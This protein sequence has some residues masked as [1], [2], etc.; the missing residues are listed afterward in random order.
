MTTIRVHNIPLHIRKEEIK[1]CFNSGSET[2]ASLSLECSHDDPQ[3]Q[4]AT[5][6][7]INKQKFKAA[8]RMDG[9]SPRSW[10]VEID[11]HFRGFTVLAGGTNYEIEYVRIPRIKS[12][13]NKATVSSHYTA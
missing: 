8:L 7:F 9:T 13:T 3:T 10:R 12:P 5:V 6:T 4:I 11:H 2:I 1:E